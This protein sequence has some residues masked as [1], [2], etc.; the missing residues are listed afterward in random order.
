MAAG[1]VDAWAQPNVSPWDWIPGAA[2]VRHA[3]G[4]AV[5]L[6][7]DPAWPLAG[8]PHLVAA[9]AAIVPRR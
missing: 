5:I 2:L 8:P 6:D 4:E 9:L 3:G 7:G 1:R